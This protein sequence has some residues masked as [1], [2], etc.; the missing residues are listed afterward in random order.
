MEGDKTFYIKYRDQRLQGAVLTHVDDFS[1]AGTEE[2]VK[3]IIVG[4][5]EDLTVSKVERDRFQ[6]TGL[7]VCIDGGRIKIISIELVKPCVWCP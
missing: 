4:V 1:L 7:D 6:F 5:E 2:F 3:E